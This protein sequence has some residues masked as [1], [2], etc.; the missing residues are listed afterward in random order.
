V[1]CGLATTHVLTAMVLPT[2]TAH[3]DIPSK[4][5]NVDI[6][7]DGDLP[8][9]GAFER[10]ARRDCFRVV[11]QHSCIFVGCST[12]HF[13]SRQLDDFFENVLSNDSHTVV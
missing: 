3:K 10:L 11:E 8:K 6:G 1:S 9:L 2:A 12:L 7:G 5:A 13:S 4:D